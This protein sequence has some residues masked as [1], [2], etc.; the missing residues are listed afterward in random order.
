MDQP[1]AEIPFTRMV[2]ALAAAL[3]RRD[4]SVIS[5]TRRMDTVHCYVL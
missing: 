1:P 3:Y 2:K 5:R 4:T